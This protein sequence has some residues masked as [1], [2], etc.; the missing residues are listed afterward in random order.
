MVDLE[1]RD[2]GAAGPGGP[3]IPGSPSLP[4]SPLGPVRPSGPAAPTSP[5]P[6]LTPRGPGGP[7]LPWGPSMPWV[8][9]QRIAVVRR[10]DMDIPA[11]QT[12]LQAPPSPGVPWAQVSV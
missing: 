12:V 10:K 3:G 9:E 6:P 2:M 5:W 11:V 8:T 7:S 1:K 4:G